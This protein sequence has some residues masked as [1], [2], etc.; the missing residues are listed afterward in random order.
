MESITHI[1][2]EITGKC[3]QA[4]FYC[5][6]NSRREI[7]TGEISFTEWIELIATL[8]RQGLKSVLI[9]GGEPFLWPN[10]MDLLCSAQEM[11]IDTSVLSN[12]YRISEL[13]QE[14]ANVFKN[15]TVAQI[16]LDA[17]TPALNDSRRGLVGAWRQAINAIE[18]LRALRV[19]VEISS[20]VS[21]RNIGELVAIGEYAKSMNA[22]LLVR[23]LATVG[24]AACL[25]V[26]PSS[27]K[28]LETALNQL[29][30]N[31]VDVVNDRFMYAPV[32]DNVD[33]KARLD[34]I[35]TIESN[36]NFRCGGFCL[37]NGSTVTNI[38]DFAKAA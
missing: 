9:T 38:L 17:M 12:G 18:T 27:R 7:F 36:G 2:I 23:P 5:F 10:T 32:D 28:R 14:H 31:G 8:R 13:A 11:G 34:G 20:T 37:N 30:E 1:N 16:S 25:W 19:P 35:F 15:L 6:N 33:F 22:S 21:D 4:C 29:V 24:R 26:S 3:N